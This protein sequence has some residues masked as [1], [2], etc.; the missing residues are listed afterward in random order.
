MTSSKCKSIFSLLYLATTP[1]PPPV[2]KPPPSKIW[3][4]I[5]G[6]ISGMFATSCVCKMLK[7]VKTFFDVN[8]FLY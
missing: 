6:G 4:F 5:I 7:V 1:V 2:A 3:N 8:F